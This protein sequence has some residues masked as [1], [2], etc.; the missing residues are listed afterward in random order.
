VA[1]KNEKKIRLTIYLGLGLGLAVL[2]GLGLGLPQ[3]EHALFLIMMLDMVED[4][5]RMHQ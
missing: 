2:V 1:V 3:D 5:F 4:S